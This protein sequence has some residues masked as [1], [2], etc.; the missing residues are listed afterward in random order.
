MP[1]TI[2]QIRREI[3][4][5][6]I[7]LSKE[8]DVSRSISERQKLSKE[9]FELKNRKLIGAGATA[10]RLSKKFGKAILRVGKR[11]TP[12]IKKQARLIR[13]QQLRD[14]AA[15]KKIS[16]RKPKRKKKAKRSMGTN[17]SDVFGNLDF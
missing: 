10:K 12:L 7:R 1:K 13:E 6:K 17:T 5:Q 8:K 9:L 3:A 2:A 4:R 14:D 11:A 16:K 15:A